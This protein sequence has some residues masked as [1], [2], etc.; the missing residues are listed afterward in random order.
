MIDVR[1]ALLLTLFSLLLLSGCGEEEAPPAKKVIRPVKTELIAGPGASGVRHFPARINTSNRADLSFRVAGIVNTLLV[2][3]GEKV[4]QGQVLAKLDQ[5]D[6]QIK[7]ND[8]SASFSAAKADFERA[9]TLLPKGFVS[10]QAYDQLEANY[11]SRLAD[12]NRAKQDLS[13]TVLKAPF[14]GSIGQRM[15]QNHEEVRAKQPVFALRDMTLLEAKIN[16]PQTI[17]LRISEERTDQQAKAM[18]SFESLEGQVFPLTFKEVAT[19]A[20]PKTQTF[21][22]TYTLPAPKEITILPGMAGS[23]AVDLSIFSSD[24]DEG[25]FYLPVSAVVGDITMNPEVWV[26][27]EQSMT[28]KSRKVK[29]G[30]MQTTRIEVLEGVESGERVVTAGTPFLVEGMKVR[31]LPDFEQAEPMAQPAKA[32]PKTEKKEPE[33]AKEKAAKTEAKP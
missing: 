6:Y 30:E 32:T 12:L 21:E 15:I 24:D 19:K 2:K 11:K 23:V 31:F 28:V 22:V 25:N 5:T 17:I 33:P 18:L 1:P 10:K 9:K 27:D 13:Y 20:D 7:V 29:V 8:R 4:K 3:E 14:S 26:V 16:V